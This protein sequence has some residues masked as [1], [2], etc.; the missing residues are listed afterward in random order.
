MT[1]APTITIGAK[2]PNG[3]KVLAFA[4]RPTGRCSAVVLADTNGLAG[5][6][7]ATWLA[8][9]AWNCFYGRY[10]DSLEEAAADWKER[11]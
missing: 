2:L 8:D 11:I 4:V 10:F 5:N 3:A 9:D 1:E 7:Y 6:A